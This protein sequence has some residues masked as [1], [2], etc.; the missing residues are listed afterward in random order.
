[1]LQQACYTDKYGSPN[2]CLVF[3]IA[4]SCAGAVQPGYSKD[5]PSTTWEASHPGFQKDLNWG[6]SWGP[7]PPSGQSWGQSWGPPAQPAQW[8]T[9][10]TPGMDNSQSWG[11]SGGG[12]SQGWGQSWSPP[13]PGKFA[14]A[15]AAVDQVISHVAGKVGTVGL[16]G[17]TQLP[18]GGDAA[19]HASPAQGQAT[20]AEQAGQ[21]AT[22]PTQAKPAVLATGG[23][24]GGPCRAGNAG[25]ASAGARSRLGYCRGF[26]NMVALQRP[27]PPE[28]RPPPWSS[29]E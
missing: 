1:M 7:T 26:G 21:G 10:S 18:A 19:A 29:G 27:Q 11:Q 4:Q 3:T 16:A 14:S 9:P 24:Q 20:A 12:S 6:Q 5:V 8:V 25:R 13:P 23:S 15:G 22:E 28:Y 17:V 2:K